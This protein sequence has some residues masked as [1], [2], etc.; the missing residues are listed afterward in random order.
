MGSALL[1]VKRPFR[2]YELV[3]ESEFAAAHRLREYHGACERLHGHNWRVELVIGTEKLNDLGMAVDFREIKKI[4][5]E[6]LGKF[7]H[8]YLNEL[9][10]FKEQNP[11][12]ENMARIVF[13]ECSKR[14][15]EGVRALSVAVWESPRCCARYTP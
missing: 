11:T 8:E 7:D 10:D 13:E 6:A 3:I 12:T 15:P 9:P 1:F 4:L 2:M 14:L 5:N